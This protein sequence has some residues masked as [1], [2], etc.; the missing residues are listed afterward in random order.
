VPFTRSRN[1][2]RSAVL[3]LL[4]ALF[5]Q[6]SHNRIHTQTCTQ[7]EAVLQAGVLVGEHTTVGMLQPGCEERR[8]WD[9][10]ERVASWGPRIIPLFFV[11]GFMGLR[12]C[13][14]KSKVYGLRVCESQHIRC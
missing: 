7:A 10:A 8:V 12:A 3:E 2:A 6:M 1:H 4:K 9:S 5:M 14:S 11:T 13:E